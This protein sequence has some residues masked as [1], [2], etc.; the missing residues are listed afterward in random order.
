MVALFSFSSSAAAALLCLGWGTAQAQTIED[1]SLPKSAIKTL[2]VQ[3]GNGRLG[4]VRYNTQPEPIKICV[5]VQ[6][7]S[8]LQSCADVAQQQAI[9]HVKVLGEWVCQ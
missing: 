2:P 3:C 6:D 7:G 4:M 8:R 9:N 5:S 1:H